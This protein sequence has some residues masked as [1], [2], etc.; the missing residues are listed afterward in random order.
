M[1]KTSMTFNQL[2]QKSLRDVDHM[3]DQLIWGMSAR[4]LRSMQIYK[5]LLRMVVN[6]EIICLIRT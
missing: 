1:H 3:M 5:A 6:S 4:M 2:A